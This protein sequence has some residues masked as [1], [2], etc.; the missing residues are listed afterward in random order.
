M[1]LYCFYL[2]KETID[3]KEYPAVLADLIN[4]VNNMQVALYAYTPDKEVA[5]YF[6]DTRDMSIFIERTLNVK[7]DDYEN[8]CDNHGYKQLLEIHIFSTKI[9]KDGVYDKNLV[10]LLCT[11]A[12]SDEILYNSDY[13]LYDIID[14]ISPDESINFMLMHG[15]KY[16]KDIEKALRLLMYDSLIRLTYPSEI[17]NFE[18]NVIDDIG[19]F[20]K[21]F[22]NTFNN[23]KGD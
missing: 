15:I 4:N 1:K 12:E 6:R 20:I 18:G 17:D 16:Q 8:F 7:K 19:L 11:Q 13:Y 3:T 2:C 10:K 21:L 22:G 9:V 14:M 5:K 23:K